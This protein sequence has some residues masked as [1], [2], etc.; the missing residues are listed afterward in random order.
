MRL[1]DELYFEINASGTKGDVQ[2]FVNFL[3]SG[4]LEDFF[5]ISSDYITYS[6]NYNNASAFD[7][8]SITFA[9]DDVG[10]EVDSFNPEKL[11]DVLCAAGRNLSMHG[12]IFDIDDEEYRFVSHAG[13]SSYVNTDSLEFAD[14]LDEEARREEDL[15][16]IDDVDY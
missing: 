14:E 9:N 12:N 7:E 11:L 13:D 2:R 10:I 1:H 6:D 16:D 5:E 3:L 8:V 15:E 4:D